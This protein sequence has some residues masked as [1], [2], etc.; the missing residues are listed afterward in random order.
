[1]FDKPD[2][3]FKQKLLQEIIKNKR[4]RNKDIDIRYLD[5]LGE[6]GR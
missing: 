6:G 4:I 5:S 3:K 2:D 1:L